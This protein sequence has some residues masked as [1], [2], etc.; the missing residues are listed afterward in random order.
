MKEPGSAV[1]VAVVSHVVVP[2]KTSFRCEA[3]CSSVRVHVM[4]PDNKRVRPGSVVETSGVPATVWILAAK[5]MRVAVK[6]I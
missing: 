4:R 3:V 2:Q 1:Y 6:S 5:P